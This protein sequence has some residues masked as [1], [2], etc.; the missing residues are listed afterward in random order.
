MGVRWRMM[1]LWRQLYWE[2]TF[3]TVEPVS[4][5]LHV[6]GHRLQSSGWGTCIQ[7]RD[8][9]GSRQRPRRT[10]TWLKNRKPQGH[11]ETHSQMCIYEGEYCEILSNLNNNKNWREDPVKL[12][13][14]PHFWERS[15]TRGYIS[16][17][18]STNQSGGH[19]DS[20]VSHTWCQE[21][22]YT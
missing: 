1:E 6:S 7:P 16:F 22:L 4:C 18:T 5:N 9:W 3:F 21:S 13:V 19:T 17:I 10:P 11:K 20:C 14:F 2:S 8:R 15:N 12:W